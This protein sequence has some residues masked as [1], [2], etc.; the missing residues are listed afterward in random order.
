MRYTCFKLFI[1]VVKW[2]QKRVKQIK[3]KSAKLRRDK[4]IFIV[5]ILYTLEIY[6]FSKIMSLEKS[7][8]SIVSYLGLRKL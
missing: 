4:E 6:N 1:S 8:S 7:F 5:G 2:K 3:S